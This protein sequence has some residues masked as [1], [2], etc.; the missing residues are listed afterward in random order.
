MKD[1]DRKGKILSLLITI[2]GV[3]LLIF[4]FFW[5]KEFG[6]DVASPYRKMNLNITV[7]SS[8]NFYSKSGDMYTGDVVSKSSL[9]YVT[10]EIKADKAEIH[11]VFD[12]RLLTG[13]KIASVE[14]K[15][16]VDIGKGTTADE[17]GYLMSPG[18]KNKSDFKLRHFSGNDLVTMR[19]EKEEKINDLLTYK[20]TGKSTNDLTNEFTFLPEV[21]EKYGIE[22]SFE[23][24]W[25]VEP[26][27][28]LLVK[29]VESGQNTFVDLKDKS[30][31]YPRNKYMN[32]IADES[33][34]SLVQNA[35][36]KSLNVVASTIVVPIFLICFGS[37]LILGNLFWLGILGGYGGREKRMGIIIRTITYVVPLST[38][39]VTLF[40]TAILK[41]W[42]EDQ[43]FVEF[44]Q[45][46]GEIE[47][48]ISRR[49]DMYVNA[50]LGG[51][52]LF[53]ASDEVNS[54]EWKSYVD[55][56][57][58]PSNFQG[59]SYFGFNQWVDASD[60]ADFV[61]TMK[62]DG[63]DD[64][65]IFPNSLSIGGARVLSRFI[66]PLDSEAE[67]KI[68]FDMLSDET[69]KTALI[70]ARDT[71]APT[72]TGKTTLAV[73][74]GK[75]EPGVVIFLPVYTNGEDVLSVEQRR[76]KHIGYVSASIRIKD[77]MTDLFSENKLLG[78]DIYD[79]TNISDEN[80]MYKAPI[81]NTLSGSIFEQ[82]KVM[83][84]LGRPWTVV[85]KTPAL[86]LQADNR[87]LGLILTAG[88]GGSV[89]IF[90]TLNSLANSNNRA[91]EIA[92]LLTSDLKGV[93]EKL[94]LTLS[95]TGV[96]TW[97]TDQ[98]SGL[99]EMGAHSGRLLGLEGE[100]TMSVDEL[101][102]MFDDG[103]V[104]QLKMM[105][106]G[107][108][109]VQE[110]TVRITDRKDNTV[111]WVMFKGRNVSGEDKERPKQEVGILTD[112][113]N[114]KLALMKLEKKTQE[115]ERI[116]ELMVGRELKMKEL[117]DKLKKLKVE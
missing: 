62:A 105:F 40:F 27:T 115:L 25:W 107:S 26:N 18:G 71:A 15:Y 114:E 77:L 79:S 89:L 45:Q 28:G 67:E 103:E 116:N 108:S 55:S 109:E 95:G 32:E 63:F 86:T 76:K 10:D 78:F 90:L 52:G 35:R 81:T 100:T 17:G 73:D 46:T 44:G 3:F 38:I 1:W 14:R 97:S 111:R 65:M 60:E 66:E 117:K 6:P 64:Y 31:I 88:L 87:I 85:Y 21:P 80:L 37:I 30:S 16:L 94:A 98:E 20:F 36:L 61:E 4:A 22:N 57:A 92:D 75:K 104:D 84:V 83:Y 101:I 68:G 8:D 102:S 43:K 59:M 24:S 106:A 50:L 99:I 112:V 47:R 11:G 23:V 113:T 72:V 19:F 54:V 7:H 53:L 33:V 56:L 49:F 69:R 91:R 34:L 82:R 58:V 2:A 74:M 12:V 110:A 51:R 5:R 48:S 42:N 93:N 9:S 13:V 29:F 96:G 41:V 39:L 70:S